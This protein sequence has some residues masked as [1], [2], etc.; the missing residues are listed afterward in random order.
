[1]KICDTKDA[2]KSLKVSDMARGDVFMW[3]DARPYGYGPCLKIDDTKTSYAYLIT[4][5]AFKD[6]SE[7]AIIRYPNACITLGDPE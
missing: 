4:G 2:V 6:I 1:M 5:H 7:L 3:V